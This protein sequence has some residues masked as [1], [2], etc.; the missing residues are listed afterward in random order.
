MG[1]TKKMGRTGMRPHRQ[2]GR[3]NRRTSKVDSKRYLNSRRRR[4]ANKK[5]KLLQRKIDL[6][7]EKNIRI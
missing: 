3:F 5:D 6:Y 1:R 4:D 7:L 2:N